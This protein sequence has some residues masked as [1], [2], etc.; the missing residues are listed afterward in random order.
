M[1]VRSNLILSAILAALMGGVSITAAQSVKPSGNAAAIVDGQVISQ[2]ELE[3]AVQT[4]LIS[5]KSQEYNLKRQW[6][7]DRIDQILLQKEA[8][9]R[10]ISVEQ[11]TQKEIQDK[12]RP[13]TE[14]QL[15]AIYESTKDQY[16]QKTEAEALKQIE[17]NL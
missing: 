1:K 14:D 11:L 3:T 12:V 17:S 15:K 10:G 16:G 13:A 2:S 7:D 6:L 9:R 4:R 5:L 8:A